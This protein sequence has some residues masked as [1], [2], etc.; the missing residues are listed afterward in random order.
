LIML[1][2]ALMMVSRFRYV[3]VMNRYF[4]GRARFGVVVRVVV[5]LALAMI[6]PREVFAGAFVVY[7]LSAPGLWF[8]RV[9]IRKQVVAPSVISPRSAE[10]DNRTREAS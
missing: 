8:W 1:V 10:H 6:R 3:H 9:V 5:V 2:V 7:A 4:R